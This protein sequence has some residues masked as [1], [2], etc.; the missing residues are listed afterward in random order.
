MYSLCE[1][2]KTPV[3][4]EKLEQE[5]KW[6]FRKA[7]HSGYSQVYILKLVCDFYFFFLVMPTYITN[8]FFTYDL[9]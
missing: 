4:E 6:H 3:K 5:A 1:K 9:I 2:E 8:Y 7:S